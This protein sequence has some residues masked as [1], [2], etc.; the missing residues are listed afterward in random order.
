MKK[1]V[2]EILMER[3]GITKQEA[4]DL[5]NECRDEMIESGSDDAMMNILGLEPDYVVEVLGLFENMCLDE[6]F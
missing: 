5:I 2:I 1:G 3:D 4:I 6:D